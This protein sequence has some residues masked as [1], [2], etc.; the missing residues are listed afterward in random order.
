MKLFFPSASTVHPHTSQCVL[1]STLAP[2]HTRS[3]HGTTTVFATAVPFVGAGPPPSAPV[4]AASQYG[5]RVDR[6]R[7]QAALLKKGQDLRASQ[8]KPGGAMKKRFWKD[9]SVRQSPG[10]I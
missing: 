6:R 4:P 7:R 2:T 8:M 3:L 10:M 1:R 5:E 9:V